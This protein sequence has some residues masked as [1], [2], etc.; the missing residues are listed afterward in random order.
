M[1]RQNV[2]KINFPTFHKLPISA[3]L[4]QNFK[5]VF[6]WRK[7]GVGLPLVNIPFHHRSPSQT[8]EY[9][10]I[11]HHSETLF[12]P[13]GS[14]TEFHSYTLKLQIDQLYRM[15]PFSMRKSCWFVEKSL[16]TLYL[17][18]LDQLYS[19][20]CRAV[21]SPIVSVLTRDSDHDSY[22]CLFVRGFWR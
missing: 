22:F 12:L 4:D 14:T 9:I 15:K 7:R 2:R 21:S 3:F 8:G 5:E 1:F 20:E 11:P 16:Y 6:R 19:I 18:R 13:F 17:S 10:V